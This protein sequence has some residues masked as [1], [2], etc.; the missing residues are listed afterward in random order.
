MKLCDWDQMA[1][2]EEF[3]P[4]IIEMTLKSIHQ[5]LTMDLT[6]KSLLNRNFLCCLQSAVVFRLANSKS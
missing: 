1:F 6:Y 3:S 4:T 5:G 2:H